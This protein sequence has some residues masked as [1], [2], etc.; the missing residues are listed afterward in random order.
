MVGN[1]LWLW[2]G[3]NA[4]TIA[5]LAIDL[6][7]FH[8]KA[9]EIRAREAAIW[10]AVWIAVSLLFNLV[11]LVLMGRAKALE[12][13]T[14][15]LIEKSLS[16]DNI[17]VFVLIFSYFRVPAAFQHR[18]L[19]WGVVG[20]ILLRALFI[21]GG[22]ALLH[23]FHWLVYLL[24][25]LL[26]YAGIQMLRHDKVGVEPE[27]NRVLRLFRRFVPMLPTYEGPRLIVRREGRLFA[28][29][30][31]AVLI[32]IETTDIV[33]A[34]DSIP[35]ILAISR[36]PFIV[37]SSNI[38]AI[39]GL[40]ALYFLFAVIVDRLRYLRFSLALILCFVGVKMAF[41]HWVDRFITVGHA[42]MFVAAAL[43]VGVLAS[44]LPQKSAVEARRNEPR[45]PPTSGS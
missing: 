23:T 33:F 7:V 37:Y 29:P 20:A 8:R 2:V 9:H 6:G 40:R 19:F 1:E 30:L 43:G 34:L 38:C 13:L 10:S 35:A 5:M 3:F 18:V 4:L 36:D 32:A 27:K 11:I 45:T 16:V 41:G 25:V 22:I 44:F 14:G 17:F 39:L 26:I 15:Y 21:F 31:M 28:T 12:F 24:G 42:L